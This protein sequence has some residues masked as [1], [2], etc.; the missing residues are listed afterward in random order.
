MSQQIQQL[1]E[2]ILTLSEKAAA[3]Q[4]RA[5]GAKRGLTQVES[6]DIGSI[7][8]E[9]E[10]TQ[11]RLS[12]A[13]IQAGATEPLPRK[14]GPGAITNAAGPEFKAFGDYIRTGKL[15]NAASMTIAGGSDDGAATVPTHVSGQIREVA[16]AQGAI[17]GLATVMQVPTPVELPIATTLPGAQWLVETDTR[18]DQ[19]VPVIKTTSLPGG[20][21]SSVVPVSTY[22]SNDTAWPLDTFITGAIGR[23]FGVTEAAAFLNG[24]GEDGQ[25]KG[26]LDYTL[27]ATADGSR[28][29]GSLE[30]LATGTSGSGIDADFILT[31]SLKLD[32]SYRKN[33]AVV[34]HPATYANVL[35]EKASG[36]GGYLLNAASVGAFLPPVWGMPVFLDA[37]MPIQGADSASVLVGDFR[38]GYVI[39]DVGAMSIVR[40]PYAKYGFVKV[41]CEQRIRAGVLDFNAIKVGACSA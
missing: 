27:A 31:L 34:M 11:S 15:T 6:A 26:I 7:L 5:D 12:V 25:V 35:T 33:A 40:D 16:A 24:T 39:Q 4:A 10:D 13:R 38:A 28:A 1:Q 32:P 29:W 3:I 30:K 19:V 20:S 2:K 22:L 37:N 9:F 18:D 17:R 14:T 8:A 41:W 36:A 23:A 21:M